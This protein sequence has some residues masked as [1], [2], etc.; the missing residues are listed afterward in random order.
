MLLFP[1]QLDRLLLNSHCARLVC[2]LPH[3]QLESPD[4]VPPVQVAASIPRDW[5]KAELAVDGPTLTFILQDDAMRHKLAVVS[6]HCSGVVISRSSPSQKAATVKMMTEYEM[7]K[8]AGNKRGIRRWY[9]RHSRRLQV[10]NGV[11]GGQ[12]LSAA[13]GK[14]CQP[15]FQPAAPAGCSVC[16]SFQRGPLADDLV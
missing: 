8:A 13:A 11:L 12:G 10:R 5:Q 16:S 6:A 15:A 1:L 3:L 7:W 2:P 4:K 14:C 9:A